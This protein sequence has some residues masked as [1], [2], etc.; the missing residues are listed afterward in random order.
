MINKVEI[1]GVNT[2][3]L[4][5]LS[6]VEKNELLKKIK[7]GDKNAKKELIELKKL[8]VIYIAQ[9]YKK[10]TNVVIDFDDL[11]S[12]GL[13]G[14]LIAI[15]NYD[16][17][18]PNNKKFDI[19]AG[20][21]IRAKMQRALSTSSTLHIPAS[22]YL[23]WVNTQKIIDEYDRILHKQ[24]TVEEIAKRLNISTGR[25]KNVINVNEGL[26]IDINY[27]DIDSNACL[28]DI[29]KS[30]DNIEESVM[31]KLEYEELWKIITENL[32]EREQGIIRL[33]FNES[34][35]LSQ[36]ADKYNLS[37]ERIRQLLY[38]TLNKLKKHMHKKE[39]KLVFKYRY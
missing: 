6:N 9:L 17:D 1:C 20:H 8:Y 16:I 5:V 32:T 7:N 15:K 39:K 22:A 28:K 27:S 31:N 33:Y 10:R 3:K 11:I 37:T 30:D 21:Y 29:I 23:D 18:N 4:P 12:Y 14:L 36:I 19:Y 35:T 13:E 2:A 38:K 26:S 25:V 34:L 24:P